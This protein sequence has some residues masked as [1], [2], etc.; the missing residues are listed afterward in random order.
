MSAPSVLTV[1]YPPSFQGSFW[2]YPSYRKGAQSLYARLQAGIDEAESILA[3]VAHRAE[4]EYKHAE[5][6]A[7]P[8]PMPTFTAPLF[9][10]AGGI[11]SEVIGSP[12]LGRGA[13]TFGETTGAGTA[14][15]R[16]F[17][18]NETGSSHVF[19]LVQNETTTAQANAHGKTARNLERL[20]LD[21]FTKWSNH[22]KERVTS[23]WEHV[24]AALSRFE[25][26]KAEVDKLKQNYEKKCNQADEAE[27]DAKF[28]PIEDQ[29]H[30]A[31]PPQR[32]VSGS[33]SASVSEV[34][35]KDQDQPADP[36]KLKRRETLRKQFGFNDRSAASGAQVQAA[37]SEF[38]G[39]KLPA[40]PSETDKLADHATPS[41]PG[42]LG[43]S[44]VTGLKRSGTIGAYLHSAVERMPTP[45]KVA[46]GGV[47]SGEPKHVRLRRDADNAERVYEE[48]VR[49][50][51]RTRCQLEEILYEHFGLVQKWE[52]DRIR[53]VKSVLQSY[54]TAL[55][56]GVPAMS[57]SIERCVQLQESL[58]PDLELRALI[59]DARTGPFRP[60]MERFRPYYHDEISLGRSISGQSQASGWMIKNGGFGLDLVLVERLDFLE[61]MERDGIDAISSPGKLAALPPVL[62]ALL[63]AL[64]RAYADDQRW[65]NA[66]AAATS[67]AASAS[68]DAATDASKGHSE[69]SVLLIRS[70]EK[71]KTWIY[72]V[73]LNVTH[74]LRDAL[75]AHLS[76]SH[77]DM[78]YGK[79][80]SGSDAASGSRLIC[81]SMLDAYDPP[82]LAACIRIW[83]LE[84]EKSLVPEELWDQVDSVYRAA[85][86]Q[87]REALEAFAAKKA[88]E[89]EP[90]PADAAEAE[91][92]GKGKQAA[93]DG[94]LQPDLATEE[95]IRR[96]VL[97]DL[98]VVLSKLPKLHLACLDAIIGHLHQL[99]KE[100]KTEESDLVYLNKVGLALG[101]AIIRPLSET[102]YTFTSRHPT[103]LVI[104][105]IKY[106]DQIFPP[107]V[108]KKLN[109]HATSDTA[110][111]ATGKGISSA[112]AG[113]QRKMPI[114]KRTKPVDQRISRS[115]IGS[116]L[117]EGAKRLAEQFGGRNAGPPKPPIKDETPA[118]PAKA[119]TE[120]VPET[121]PEEAQLT[122]FETPTEEVDASAALPPTAPSIDTSTL[123]GASEKKADNEAAPTPLSQRIIGGGGLAEVPAGAKAVEK[124]SEEPAEEAMKSPKPPLDDEDKPLSNVARL[125]RQFASG[126]SLKTPGSG[127]VRG[128][129]PA[130]AR[131]ARLS[132]NFSSGSTA[133]S[134]GAGTGASKRESLDLAP[135]TATGEDKRD[136]RRSWSRTIEPSDTLVED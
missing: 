76:P 7:T 11:L 94:S 82:V 107:L 132:G 135:S 37:A 64:R 48:A 91:A 75:I 68:G 5:A 29:S 134:A 77:A 44:K 106:Y 105:L 108:E 118:V 98:G 61:Q 28:A 99:V 126:G 66:I 55:S 43:G 27:D 114:R 79:Q 21:P 128:P 9:R 129:R 111:E 110:D 86:G 56:G 123:V 85:A 2:S 50:L 32:S 25:R 20:I 42:D 125:S 34:P 81:N 102:L 131:T 89:E 62:E 46:V 13:S 100:T 78:I 93:A 113:G 33:S 73:P 120:S 6:L 23:S 88:A 8:A 35:Q 12:V 112:V 57:Q 109:E 14:S 92:S 136:R 54:N 41:S 84:L 117:Q 18:Y 10:P 19:R 103:L 40:P 22:H 24:D 95:K 70:Q 36:E 72:E 116:D 90:H 67:A 130:G 119:S 59:R 15:G 58:N 51:D 60:A 115:S 122:P 63:G 52:S 97:D 30:D 65:P 83:M 45:L 104:D 69:E 74:R 1:I 39:V 4:L 53:A 31:A 71:R 49:N 124:A 3:F 80:P 87:E 16:G 121:V 38:A 47:V 17:L 26:Q 127:A 101:R 96:G 133:S